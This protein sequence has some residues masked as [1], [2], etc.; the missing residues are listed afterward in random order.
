M[1]IYVY[2]LSYIVDPIFRLFRHQTHLGPCPGL[3]RAEHHSPA[4]FGREARNTTAQWGHGV[5]PC[6]NQT[7][8]VTYVYIAST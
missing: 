3:F 7:G 8:F 5:V 1:F 2:I 4:T 6:S